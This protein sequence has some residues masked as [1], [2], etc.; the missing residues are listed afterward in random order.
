MNDG[1]ANSNIATRNISVAAVNDAPVVTTT[2]TSSP[3]PRTV[4]PRRSI[5]L[6]VSDADNANLSSV[7]VT[8]TTNFASGQDVLAFADQNGITG[9]WNAGTGVLTPE[10]HGTVAKYQTALRSITYVNTSDDPSTPARTVSVRGQR[11]G[12]QQQ[13]RHAQRQRR[14]VNDA[15]CGHTTGT[16]CLYRERCGHG[17]RQRITVSDADNANLS[18]AT[19]TITQGLLRPR[20]CWRSPTKRHHR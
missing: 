14:A 11:W 20:T 2:G 9:S 10:R 8:I 1:G 17:D 4:L 3:T 7:T 6:D 19:V 5:G 13:H 18:S 12:R 16:C 15:P